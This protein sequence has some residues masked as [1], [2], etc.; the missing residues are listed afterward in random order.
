MSSHIFFA[1]LASSQTRGEPE[2]TCRCRPGRSYL[3]GV[4]YASSQI[5]DTV[6]VRW[7]SGR[8]ISDIAL[9]RGIYIM[10][11]KGQ[12]VSGSSSKRGGPVFCSMGKCGSRLLQS[13]SALLN[14]SDDL[15]GLL[16]VAL[17]NSPAQRHVASSVL[18]LDSGFDRCLVVRLRAALSRIDRPP[19]LPS[20]CCLGCGVKHQG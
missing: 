8:S 18:F 6:L 15:R 11:E 9:K 16:F 12:K 20:C 7:I 19:V 10:R 2:A 13:H 17:V 1:R 4:Q 3:A 5:V 14:C